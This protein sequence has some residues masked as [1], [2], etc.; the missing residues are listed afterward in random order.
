[1]HMVDP[2]TKRRV[3]KKKEDMK[4]LVNISKYSYG[5]A[6]KTLIETAKWLN[7]NQRAI[8]KAILD[9]KLCDEF[10]YPEYWGVPKKI[11]N[12]L[13]SDEVDFIQESV[14][15]FAEGLWKKLKEKEDFNF[16]IAYSNEEGRL[17]SYSYLGELKYGNRKQ[18]ESLLK[19]VKTQSPK[20]KWDIVRI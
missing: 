13:S 9:G 10:D 17:S 8:A 5:R 15:D 12:K 16:L 1:M 3:S 2:R 11:A 7:A 6:R 20:H 4:N 18:A 14:C 19:Y